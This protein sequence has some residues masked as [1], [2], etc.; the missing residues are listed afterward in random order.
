MRQTSTVMVG[1]WHGVMCA[2]HVDTDTSDQALGLRQSWVET[3]ETRAVTERR[4]IW[5]LD[6]SGQIWVM[7]IKYHQV[8]KA[9]EDMRHLGYLGISWDEGW[10]T[11][12]NIGEH[13]WTLVNIGERCKSW[14]E[15]R[16]SGA[17]RRFSPPQPLELPGLPKLPPSPVSLR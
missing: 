14:W 8:I 2:S 7:V 4:Q 11:L 16:F 13:W 9:T 15:R 6:R 17:E 12:V 3:V 5:D 10:W 1:V